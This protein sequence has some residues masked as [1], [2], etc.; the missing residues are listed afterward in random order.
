MPD[1]VLRARGLAK[2][3]ASP[4]GPLP[5]LKDVSLEVFAGESVSIRGSSGSGKTTLLQQLGGLDQ[6]DAGEVRILAPG[7]GLVAP[8]ASLGRG[9]GFVFQNYQ[10]MPE[11]TALENVALAARIVGTPVAAAEEAARA[12]LTQVGLGARLEH[13]PAKLSGGECQRVAIARA[14]VNRPSVIL[15]DEPT[16]NLDE[17]TGAEIMDLLLG[18]VAD[19]GAAL[20]LVT[21]SREFAE[22]ASRRL[23]LSGGVLSPA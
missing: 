14:L 10:L 18:V 5:V 2:V 7:A 3:F 22:R 12:L 21:H 23:V 8:R 13:L 1:V 6:P 11:L 19:R 17:R 20:I 16:G 15:A 9:V 4:A